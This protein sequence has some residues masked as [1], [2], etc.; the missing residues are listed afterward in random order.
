[1][2]RSGSAGDTELATSF[3]GL[4]D[5]ALSQSDPAPV[6]PGELPTTARGWLRLASTQQPTDAVASVRHALALN[7]AWP[8]AQAALCVALAAAKDPGALE[9]C[10]IAVRARP[11]VPSVLAA[12]G[13]VLITA[14]RFTDALADLDRVVAAD[15]DPR[16]RR[17]RAKAREGAG[18]P[19]GA[20]VDLADACQLGDA[21]A[22]K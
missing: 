19:A 14:A 21:A 11:G 22:C 13:S 3:I 18:D 4:L 8:E 16:W 12:R 2:T 9:P 15:P 10:D 20:A 7:P 1:V 6:T 17:L 5:H